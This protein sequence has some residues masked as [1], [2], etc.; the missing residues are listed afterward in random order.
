MADKPST[1]KK[2]SA[3]SQSSANPGNMGVVYERSYHLQDEDE[4]EVEDIN[5]VKGLF[6]NSLISSLS[7]IIS[8]QDI[9]MV[10]V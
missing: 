9:D 4:T 8:S 10:K 1:W 6:I 7:L 5:V 3:I 2:I